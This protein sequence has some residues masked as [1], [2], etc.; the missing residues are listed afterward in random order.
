MHEIQI[1]F[2]LIYLLTILLS[3][4]EIVPMSVGA[5]IGALLTVVFGLLY[6]V[7]NYGDAV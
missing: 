2:I 4:T 1:L 6:N 3:A 7:C 5:L